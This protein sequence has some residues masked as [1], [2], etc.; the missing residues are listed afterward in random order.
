MLIATESKYF[1]VYIKSVDF[2]THVR[3]SD[4]EIN[5]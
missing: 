3:S 2:L 5:E 4:M 1:K